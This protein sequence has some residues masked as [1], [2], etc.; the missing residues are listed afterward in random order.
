MSA[1]IFYFGLGMQ[2]FGIA[3]VGLCF[4]SGI[5]QGDYGR[6]ELAQ[7]IIGSVVFYTG[8]YFKNKTQS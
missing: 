2:L 6:I 1:F 7:L 8:S 3:A 5:T 4:F